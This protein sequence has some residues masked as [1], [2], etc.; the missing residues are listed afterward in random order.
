MEIDE[1][2]LDLVDLYQRYNT[3]PTTGLSYSVVRKVFDRDGPNA[4]SSPKIKPQWI[5]F[6]RHLFGH[7]G[8]LLWIAAILSFI[9]H[10]IT[11]ITYNKD[12]SNDNLWVGIALTVIVIATGCFSYFQDVKCSQMVDSFNNMVP[13]QA[14]VIR[15]GQRMNLP[16]KEIVVGDIVETKFG[17]G[18]PADIRIIESSD[19]KVDNS[20]LTGE[21]EPQ[22]RSPEFTNDNVLETKNMAFLSTMAVNGVAKGLVIRTGD[23]TVMGRIINHASTPSTDDTPIT[24]EIVHFIHIITGIAVFLGI[25]FFIVSLS[26]GYP[27]VE[28]IIFFVSIIIAIV[29]KGFLV[30]VTICLTVITGRLAKKNCLVKNSAAIE[31]LGSTSIICADKIGTL[32]QNR[33]TIAHMWFDNQI[34][35]AD[36]TESQQSSAY[37]RSVPG[38][39]ALARCAM[40]CNRGDFR[41]DPENLARPV[42]EREMYGDASEA[43]LLK[44]VELSIGNV[45]KFREI[46]QKVF[47]IPFNSTNKY[48][49]SIHETQDGDERFLLVMKGAPERILDRCSSIYI[50]GTDIELNDYW[51]DAFNQAYMKLGSMGERVLG[52]CDLR[53]PIRDYPKDYQFDEEQINF[54]VDNL[55]FLGLMS[56]ADPPRAAVPETIAKCRSAGIKVIMVTG[57]HPITANTIARA[58]GIISE[59]SETVDDIALRLGVPLQE[60]NP[61]DVNACIIHGNDLKDMSSAEIDALLENHKEIVFARTSPQQKVIVI[62]GC[63]RQGAIVAMIGDGVNDSPAMKEAD[64]GIAMGIVGSD[65]TKQTADMILLDD[66]FASIVTGIEQGRLIFD[67]LKKSIAY[68][69]TSNIPKMIPFLIY[70]LMGIPLVLGISTILFIDLLTIISTI[71]LAYEEAETDI[72]KRRPRNPQQDRLVNKRL[73]LMTYGPIGFI[74]AAAGL[75][76]Y[77]MIMAENGFLP[78]RLFGLRK[79]WESKYINDLQDSYNREW[80]YEERKQL[81]FTCQSAFFIAIVICQ[82]A[83]LIICKTRRNSILKQG[84]KNYILNG[85]LIFE[86]IL[87]ATIS[88]IPYFGTALNIYSVKPLPP[89]LTT[90]RPTKIFLS[91]VLPPNNSSNR[92][93]TGTSLPVVYRSTT[94]I[95]EIKTNEHTNI[96]S[97]TPLRTS[98]KNHGEIYTNHHRIQV[99]PTNEVKR[100]TSPSPI[101]SQQIIDLQPNITVQ[102]QRLNSPIIKDPLNEAYIDRDHIHT[103]LLTVERTH[104][105]D[106]DNISASK[107]QDLMYNPPILSAPPS[108]P[109]N[110]MWKKSRNKNSI[111]T[112]TG[113]LVTRKNHRPSGRLKN[114]GDDS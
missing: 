46:N 9:A 6:C 76:T 88:Y 114:Y 48:Q 62:E 26:F 93:S 65:M 8:F 38:W 23:H 85:V 35:E 13:L 108:S 58:T 55:R 21:S 74:Q 24:K 86:I 57:D 82:W 3:N 60:V 28:A 98:S 18:V 69:L 109:S 2:R 42:L 34:V 37:D 36:T 103:Q 40:L 66:N 64:I 16:T 73:I 56:M 51:R 67:N 96:R 87:V 14:L 112:G 84:M 29:P 41:Q 90:R 7:F 99:E 79:S 107:Q 30:T 104:K 1:H 94:T 22:L 39:L 78:L 5:K 100:I 11:V 52:F 105:N 83:V 53:L 27:L 113:T 54:P 97:R 95:N 12:A 33:M 43:A 50:D 75:T 63:K 59:N 25:S 81:Q 102:Y 17:D 91:N 49:V 89:E 45:I 10:G 4:L 19:F 15:D 111:R 72:M 44:C 61:N 77:F 32:T 71:S 80:T 70:F 31:T 106:N 101:K 110:P 68:M 20:S 92:T 47:E